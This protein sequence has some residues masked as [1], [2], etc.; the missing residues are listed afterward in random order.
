MF[1]IVIE[2]IREIRR[3]REFNAENCMRKQYN[4]EQYLLKKKEEEENRRLDAK[5]EEIKNRISYVIDQSP[6]QHKVIF[7]VHEKER[8]LYNNVKT[9]FSNLGFKV[10]LITVEDLG[11]DELM[12]ISWE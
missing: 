8:D 6:D 4:L 2:K 7:Q 5:I 11:T 3:K 9:Y 10:V 1:R 12:I